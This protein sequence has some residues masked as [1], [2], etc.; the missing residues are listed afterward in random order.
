MKYRVVQV[1]SSTFKLQRYALCYWADV[2]ES[3]E[4]PFRQPATKLFS[5]VA[6]AEQYAKQQYAEPKVVSEFEV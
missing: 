5:S 3:G 6:E 4:D 1:D 2:R